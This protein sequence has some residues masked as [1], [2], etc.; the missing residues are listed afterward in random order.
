MSWKTIL[1]NDK[2]VQT[3]VTVAVI[4]V[5]VAGVVDVSSWSEVAISSY[6]CY[7]SSEMLGCDWFKSCHMTFT[8]MHCCP[9]GCGSWSLLNAHD[10]AD[11]IGVAMPN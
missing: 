3:L 1:T 11:T 2:C 10:H 7:T 6:Y 4:S 5:T 9:G 8:K